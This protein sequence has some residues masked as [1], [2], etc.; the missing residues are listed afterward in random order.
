MTT[1]IRPNIYPLA[2]IAGGADGA[3]LTATGVVTATDKVCG[4][5][6]TTNNVAYDGDDFAIEA[7]DAIVNNTGVDLTG[8]TLEFIIARGHARG[9]NVDRS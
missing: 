1:H 4:C 7:D 5:Y 3:A 8:A 6:D 9:W 2:G